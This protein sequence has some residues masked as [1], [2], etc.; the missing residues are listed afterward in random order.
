MTILY[1]ISCCDSV[2]EQISAYVLPRRKSAWQLTPNSFPMTLL[3]WI[4]RTYYSWT[5]LL[6]GSIS[7]KCVLLSLPDVADG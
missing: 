6:H 2:C 7:S 3:L 4:L 1:F 5:T